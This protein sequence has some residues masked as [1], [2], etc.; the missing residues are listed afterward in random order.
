MR[1]ILR[2]DAELL[3]AIISGD[4]K[5]EEDLIKKFKKGLIWLC[6]KK[7]GNGHVEDI[8]QETFK[9]LFKSLR[10]G[11]IK[12]QVSLRDYIY[13]IFKKVIADHIEVRVQEKKLILKE[14]DEDF[15]DKRTPETEFI[16]REKIGLIVEWIESLPIKYREIVVLHYLEGYSVREI[17]ALTK[18]PIGT[19]CYRLHIGRKKILKKANKKSLFGDLL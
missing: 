8:I 16:R 3:R 11:I 15:V 13:G 7:I 19:I 5:A 18:L 2:E 14:D 17:S 12:E 1:D 9:N 10:K 6:E 4:K